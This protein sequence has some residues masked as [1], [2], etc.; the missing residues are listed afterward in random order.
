MNNT[1][2]YYKTIT[3]AIKM[4]ISVVSIILLYCTVGYGQKDELKP[5]CNLKDKNYTNLILSGSNMFGSIIQNTDFSGSVMVNC[6]LQ[7]SNFL[8]S[9]FNRVNFA[10][11]D[12]TAADMGAGTKVNR[13]NFD[14]ANL[15]MAKFH[16]V[17]M[18]SCLFT[19]TT[20]LTHASFD[21]CSLKNAIFRGVNLKHTSFEYADLSNAVFIDVILDSTLFKHANLQGAYFY[22]ARENQFSLFGNANLSNSSLFNCHFEKSSF[23]AAQVQTARIENTKFNGSDIMSA[24]F[25][26]SIIKN[27]D[28]S[29]ALFNATGG[30]FLDGVD[31]IIT[32]ESPGSFT[33]ATSFFSIELAIVPQN[34]HRITGLASY[35]HRNKNLKNLIEIY[36]D[37]NFR[38]VFQYKISGE[39]MLHTVT[40]SDALTDNSYNLIVITYNR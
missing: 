18:D 4:K 16:Q 1:Y 34:Q 6:R 25:S 37:E 30:L 24:D 9:S 2:Q 5:G 23:T 13:S 20:N 29:G 39:K 7:H 8:A 11:A 22:G 33:D 21:S 15:E 36:L 38:L 35:N 27:C 40:S 26:G 14:G 31:D 19:A 3:A 17:E 32:V 10:Y 28:F 12:L